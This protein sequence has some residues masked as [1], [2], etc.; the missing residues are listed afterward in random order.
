MRFVPAALLSLLLLAAAGPVA[1]AHSP[2]FLKSGRQAVPV[3]DP[4]KSW[5]FYGRLQ[6]GAEAD[7]IP[8]D[9]EAGQRLKLQVLVP[10]R[11]ELRTFTPAFYVLGPGFPGAW[12]P[13]GSPVAPA[14]GEGALV[15]DQP[16][17]PSEFFE[18]F[19]Q[20]RYWTY[21]ELSGTFPATGRYRVVVYDPAK[22]GG[23]YVVALGDREDF[24]LKDLVT[25]PATWLKVRGWFKR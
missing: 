13:P 2:V 18:P 19:T 21:G 17:A 16:Q 7:V 10:K 4:E 23:P 14:R 25:F 22:M 15:A 11:Q 20:T 5:A 9:A 3:T 1:S 8:V 12:V 24:G 6:P